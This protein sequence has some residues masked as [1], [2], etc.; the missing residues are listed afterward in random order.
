MLTICY[1]AIRG[2]EIDVDDSSSRA[3]I[4]N[5]YIEEVKA[6]TGKAFR[7]AASGSS[8]RNQGLLGMCASNTPESIEVNN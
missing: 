7:F 8:D 1:S 5:R 2:D 3:Q 4:E 6:L